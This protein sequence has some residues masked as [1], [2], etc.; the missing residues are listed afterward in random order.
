MRF[1]KSRFFGRSDRTLSTT[2]SLRRSIGF[3]A[4]STLFVPL[5]WSAP[6]SLIPPSSLDCQEVDLCVRIK[7]SGY[8]ICYWPYVSIIPSGVSFLANSTS[9]FLPLAPRL[10]SGGCAVRCFI[11]GFTAGGF[12]QL[13]GSNLPCTLGRIIC[14]RFSRDPVRQQRSRYCRA[15][16]RLMNQAWEDTRGGNISPPRPW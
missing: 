3:R 9:T 8:K 12:M 10:F 16:I 5:H 13:S 2:A 7:R 11:T 15:L 14:N 4:L 1:P 6:A